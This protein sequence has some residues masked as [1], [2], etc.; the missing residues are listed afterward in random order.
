MENF[1]TLCLDL[2]KVDNNE[3]DTVS[4]SFLLNSV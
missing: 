2:K 1:Y 4:G 3:L